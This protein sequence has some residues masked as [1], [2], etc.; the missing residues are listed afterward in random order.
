MLKANKANSLPPRQWRGAISQPKKAKQKR[1]TRRLI[2]MHGGLIKIKKKKKI[3][4]LNKANKFV[5]YA[6]I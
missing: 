2:N 5:H 6:I 4:H 3:K 1:T